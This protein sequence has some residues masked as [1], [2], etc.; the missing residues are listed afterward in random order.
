L[1]WRNWSTLT[2]LVPRA[3]DTG[4]SNQRSLRF[5]GHRNPSRDTV[6]ASS[7]VLST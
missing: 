5:A 4:G 6:H 2:A 7:G 3:V 1:N